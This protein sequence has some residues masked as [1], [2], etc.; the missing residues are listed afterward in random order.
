VKKSVPAADPAAYVAALT[1]W[2]RRRVQ[3]LRSAIV[4]AAPLR[5]VIKWGHLVYFSNGPVLLIRAEDARVLFGFWRGRRLQAIE[6]RLKRGGKYEMATLE[7]VEKT[8]LKMATV[9]ALV[10]EA[11]ALNVRHGDPTD[12]KTAVADGAD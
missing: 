8:P 11:V 6:P 12:L 10:K 2:Q 4:E 7:I 5:E 1:G 9:D 3:A